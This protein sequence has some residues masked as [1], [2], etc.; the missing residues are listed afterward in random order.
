MRPKRV[1]LLTTIEKQVVSLT[2]PYYGESNLLPFDRHVTTVEE[3]S[4][5]LSHE[6]RSLKGSISTSRSS[7]VFSNRT[8]G[9][10]MDLLF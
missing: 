9:E 8:I 5:C 2:P 4:F 6:E 7:F 10:L 3:Q 1:S